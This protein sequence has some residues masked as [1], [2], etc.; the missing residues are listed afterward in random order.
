MFAS[1]F[2][3]DIGLYLCVCMCMVSLSCFGIRVMLGL[4]KI[5]LE[6]LLLLCFLL[7]FPS[8]YPPPSLSPSHPSGTVIMLN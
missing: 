5:S 7:L 3:W 1:L 6:E 2:I 4:K 8:S